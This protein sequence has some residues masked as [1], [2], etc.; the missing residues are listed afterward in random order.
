MSDN[1]NTIDWSPEDFRRQSRELEKQVQE[2]K[3]AAKWMFDAQNQS[4]TPALSL[5]E[6]VALLEQT[7]NKNKG[8][9][10]QLKKVTSVDDITNP[11]SK[12]ILSNVIGKDPLK[13]LART[14]KRLRKLVKGLK[15]KQLRY[16]AA[17]GKWSI[18]QIVA[19]LADAEIV[20]SWRIRLTLAQSGMPIAAYDQDEWAKNLEYEK[21][22]ADDCVD[23]FAVLRQVNHRLL[24]RLT[25]EEWERFGMHSERGKET[26]ERMAA[27]LA[28]HDINH[29][30]QI[31]A[32]RNSFKKKKK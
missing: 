27:M 13:V 19:H 10:T 26:V 1:R 20:M 32:I 17:A 4:L 24:S 12:R 9:T 18:T 28:G 11:Y 23:V 21:A 25:D 6:A 5:Q 14:P 2:L 8:R 22:D 30:N 15:K 31:E 3:D 29:L 16:Q 7:S